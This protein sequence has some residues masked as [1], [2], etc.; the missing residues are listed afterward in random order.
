LTNAINAYISG[1]DKTFSFAKCAKKIGPLSDLQD[2]NPALIDVWSSPE[3]VQVLLGLS[4]SCSYKNVRQ[5]FDSPIAQCP[6]Y[7]LL[8]LS[9][10]KLTSGFILVDELISV[11]M[12]SVIE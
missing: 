10:V 2:A 5:I 12:T 6:Q 4:E 1:E 8:A 3:V 9:Q 11:L 7:L